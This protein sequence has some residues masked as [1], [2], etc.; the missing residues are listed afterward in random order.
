[1]GLSHIQYV[2]KLLLLV[3]VALLF[4]ASGRATELA[5]YQRTFLYLT[6]EHSEALEDQEVG[7]PGGGGG[8]WSRRGRGWE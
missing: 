2:K 6:F 1:M 5:A 3:V 4:Q 7:D 8:D